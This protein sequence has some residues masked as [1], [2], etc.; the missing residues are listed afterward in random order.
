[1][2]AA[3]H[4]SIPTAS[5]R[6]RVRNRLAP[7][8]LGV[9]T[10][11]LVVFVWG[12]RDPP[13]IIHDEAS[14]V[15]QARIF[16]RF[17]WIEA[18]RPLTRFFDQMQVF[19]T[20]VLAS[21]Y[22][23]G[24]ALLLTPGIWLKWPPLVPVLAAGAG[25][26]IFFALARRI[27]G[28]FAALTAWAIWATSPGFEVVAASFLSETTTG[29]LW[30]A[31]WW[32]LWKWRDG[33]G[34][35]WCS[36]AVLCGAWIC[37]TRPLTGMAFGIPCAVLVIRRALRDRSFAGVAKSAAVTVAVAAIVPVWSHATLGRWWPTPYAEYS[38]IYF[39]YEKLGFGEDPAPAPAPLP[40]G[41]EKYDRDYR[42]IHRNHRL[43]D[44]PR[45]AASRILP[46]VRA[47]TGDR[48]LLAVFVLVG[49]FFARRELR[50][51][52]A[53]S[54][55]LFAAYL[56]LAHP[57]SWIVYYFE[58]FP[59]VAFL[60]AL[61]LGAVFR[62]VERAFRRIPVLRAEILQTAISVFL[63]AGAVPAVADL[64]AA[65]RQETGERHAIFAFARAETS[66]RAILFIPCSE[67]RAD[68]CDAVQNRPDLSR[69][70]VWLAH[71]LGEDDRRLTALAPDRLAL[72][73]DPNRRAVIDLTPSP[74]ARPDQ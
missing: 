64:R 54:A 23:P 21:K 38:R 7:V 48:S 45:T 51:A 32:A 39:P 60:A 41:K 70:R 12:W 62:V 25:A 27:A 71:D 55:L 26:A 73:Y 63:V 66:P 49:L 50:F 13:P 3:S 46:I 57:P 53:T 16:A 18:A 17:H 61:G 29:L 44:L 42:A 20:P 56:A 14:Y 74:P 30:L 1:M 58:I 4:P 40:Y 5:R 28:P 69:E 35:K 22:P 31:G 47:A 65:R 9:A 67:R 6:A 34:E 15:L 11:A 37:L 72:R 19:T 24:H 52:V 59:V 10:S 2:I 36:L 33:A 8:A 43:A 68:L